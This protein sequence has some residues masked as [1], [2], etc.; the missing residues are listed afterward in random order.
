[1]LYLA[2]IQNKDF[3]GQATLKLLAQQKSEYVWAALSESET[4]ASSDVGD[5]NDGVL[6]LVEVSNERQVQKIE[7]ATD[8]LLTVVDQYLKIGVTPTVLQQEVQRA[9]Q[10]RQSLTL[11][12]QELARR[13]LEM[14]ARRDQIQDLE[15]S[16][17]QE[18]QE[19]EIMA[20]KLK[21]SI[22]SSA[23]N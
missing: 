19:L 15:E 7:D 4:L 17:K 21:A 5:R 23:S 8:W 10:W 11:Q 9:E 2:Q 20:A 3:S 16:L 1:M 18:K 22:N 12:S 6:V 13:A 14:E